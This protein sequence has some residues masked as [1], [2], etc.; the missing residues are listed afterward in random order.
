MTKTHVAFGGS[1][2][3]RVRGQEAKRLQVLCITVFDCVTISR[4]CAAHKFVVQLLLAT[5]S[6]DRTAPDRT[7]LMQLQLVTFSESST[8]YT[9]QNS[10]EK[11]QYESCCWCTSTF[12]G[13]TSHSLAV[14]TL[15][16]YQTARHSLTRRTQC[17][18]LQMCQV[19]EA[20]ALL[21][22]YL[23]GTSVPVR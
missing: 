20:I 13:C 1:D 16:L 10:R 18:E 9:V 6:A 3:P 23:Y 14:L 17:T 21:V 12:E 7:G 4:S 8:L 22:C 2:S 5:G 15:S 19:K 11:Y